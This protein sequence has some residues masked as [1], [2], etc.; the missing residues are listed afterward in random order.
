MITHTSTV[1]VFVRDQE[2]ALAFHTEKLGF[3]VRND[4]PMG[5]NAPRWIEVSPPGAQMAILL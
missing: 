1:T 4:R 3:K 5:P 2:K